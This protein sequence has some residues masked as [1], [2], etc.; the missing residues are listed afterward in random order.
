MQLKEKSPEG[1]SVSYRVVDERINT[2]N[3]LSAPPVVQ[4]LPP[5]P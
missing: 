1:N 4:Q 5:P 3:F 2:R